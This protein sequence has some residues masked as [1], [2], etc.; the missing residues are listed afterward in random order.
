MVILL[1]RRLEIVVLLVVEQIHGILM[2]IVL[3]LQVSIF[4]DLDVHY[5]FKESSTVLEVAHAL[6][7]LVRHLERVIVLEEV[8][9]RLLGLLI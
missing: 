8:Q 3:A 4:S 7:A 9:G 5:L 6:A 2:W 1:F